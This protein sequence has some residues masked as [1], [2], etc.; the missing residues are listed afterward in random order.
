MLDLFCLTLRIRTVE[1][2]R[3]QDLPD[4]S[5]PAAHRTRFRNVPYSASGQIFR[6][7]RDNHI[8]LVHLNPVPDAQLQFLHN[9]DIVDAGSGNG[10][11]LQLYRIENSHR[12]NQ[13]CPGRTPLDL[14]KRRLPGFHPPI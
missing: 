5:L 4:L 10:R 8:G 14:P 9:A 11:S 2:F 1:R 7:L 3:I 13:P 6:D 12:I